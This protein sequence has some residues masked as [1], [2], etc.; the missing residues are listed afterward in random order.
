VA[1]IAIDGRE[2]AGKP[3]GVGR[4][5]SRLLAAWERLPEARE[6]EYLLYV[7]R[8]VLPLPPGLPLQLRVVP[9]SSG[10][11]WEQVR[12]AAA[13]RRDRPDVLFS[14]AYSAPLAA[15]VPLVVALHDVSFVAHPEWFP[16][17]SRIRRR[18]LA[19][20]SAR[21]AAA[22]FTISRFSRSEIIARLGVPAGRVRVVPLAPGDPA[23]R[24]PAAREPMVLFAGSIFNRRHVPELIAAC[25][26]LAAGHP[27]LRLEIV[28]E[29]RTYPRQDLAAAARASGLD[30]RLAF[31]AY[32]PDD[33]LAALY[34]RASVFAFL[35]DYE[36]FGL[37]PLEALAAGVPLVL[38]DTVVAREVCGESAAYVPTGEVAAIAAALESV[39]YDAATR[40][41][42][43]GAAPA[44]L[45]RY[46]WERVGRE[47]LSV[48]LD[49]ARGGA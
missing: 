22:V 33:E 30:D 14:P 6:H 11:W 34:E 27:D 25:G 1:L 40:A 37:T 23:P 32:L 43:L 3:T 9:G 16:P 44:T 39:L 29:D 49:A 26:R 45:A 48:L 41:R 7:P 8:S 19:V 47:T 10:T 12:L 5:L 17:R 20:L 46:S 42:L 38:G 31:R 35:S 13:V 15:G 21:R 36:G 24:R 18:L 28:G 2:L 4:F